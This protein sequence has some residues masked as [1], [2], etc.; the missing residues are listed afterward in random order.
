MMGFYYGYFSRCFADDIPSYENHF[1]RIPLIY[2]KQEYYNQKMLLKLGFGYSL[3]KS[4]IKVIS[5]WKISKLFI[6]I[7]VVYVKTM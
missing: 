4:L 5:V 1:P 2:D 7:P 6:W 3:S